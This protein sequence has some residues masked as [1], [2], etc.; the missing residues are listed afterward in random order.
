MRRG[1]LLPAACATL[2]AGPA[3][4]Q[5]DEAVWTLS[6]DGGE[7]YLVYGIPDSDDGRIALRCEKRSSKVTVMAPVEHRV[8]S[9]LDASGQWRDARG[10]ANPW[11]VPVTL[12]SG[13]AKAQLPGQAQPDEMNGG[14]T[15]EAVT[16]TTSA[17]MQAFARSGRLALA[18]Y[19][20]TVSEPPV[21]TKSLGAFLKACG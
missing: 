10:R 2:I 14:S 16:P 11:P 9:K 13:A 7:A 5:D 19:G 3:T 4:A 8:A 18:A 20:E 15:V 21:P 1:L 6:L 17:V 12:S